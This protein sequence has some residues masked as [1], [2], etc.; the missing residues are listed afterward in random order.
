MKRILLMMCVPLF[1]AGP[2]FAQVA[3]EEVSWTQDT[4]FK[5]CDAD[6]VCT[7]HKEIKLD[8]QQIKVGESIGITSLDTGEPIAIISPDT[9]EPIATFTVQS[10]KWSREVKMCWLGDT[11]EQSKNYI[12]VSGCK[13]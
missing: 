3:V 2:A 13:K 1:A 12:T 5:S 10:I 9:G 6:D 7:T 11:A 8:R 4:S